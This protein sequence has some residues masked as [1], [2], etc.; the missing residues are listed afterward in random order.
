MPLPAERTSHIAPFLVM[1]IIKRADALAAQGRSIIHLSIGEPDQGTPPAVV[2]AATHAVAAGLTRYTPALGLPALRA[3]I[4]SNYARQYGIEVAAE[5]VVVTAGASGA[6]LLACAALVDPGAEVLMADPGYPC[7]RHIVAATD[8]VARLVACGPA[9]R[10]QLLPEAAAA[11]WT[12]A[13]RGL[14]VASPANPTGTSLT[15]A[16]TRALVELAESR[17]GFAIVDEIYGGLGYSTAPR[18]SAA[19][20][21]DA[22]VVNSFSKYFCMTGWRLGWLVLPPALV[23]VVERLAQN[24][25]ICPSAVAQHAALACFEAATLDLLEA[26]REEF[27]GRRDY[28]VPALQALGIEVPAPPDGAFYVYAD[29]SR[30]CEDSSHFASQL[31]EATGVCLVPGADFGRAEGGRYVRIS[32]AASRPQLEDAV[33][34]LAGFL[35]GRAR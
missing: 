34:R 24:L 35:A 29:V 14:L 16:E 3:A 11:A 23:P 5:R 32:Y 28:L 13:T 21:P 4:A 19:G 9:A 8:G 10:F 20:L 22:V 33:G 31:L 30:H 15:P 18:W 1:E 26:R 12:P 25:F 2:R 7:N 17:A 6:L 27:R